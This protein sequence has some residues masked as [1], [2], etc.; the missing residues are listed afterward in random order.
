MS[1]AR[2]FARIVS[3]I[4]GVPPTPCVSRSTAITCSPP[5]AMFLAARSKR[6]SMKLRLVL[7]SL[8]LCQDQKTVNLF[9]DTTSFFR[10]TR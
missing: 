6:L 9:C 3:A 8:S 7:L 4:V 10:D 1:A 2:I 5:F